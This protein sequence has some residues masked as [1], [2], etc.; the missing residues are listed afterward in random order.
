MNNELISI[1]VTSITTAKR[2]D[3]DKK[4]DEYVKNFI[5]TKF[6]FQ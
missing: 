4:N 5:K 3:D 2:N 1:F 6:S